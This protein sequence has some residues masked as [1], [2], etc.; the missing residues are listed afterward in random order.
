LIKNWLVSSLLLF[1]SPCYSETPKKITIA[2]GY[3]SGG[4]TDIASK[5]LAKHLGKYIPG[6]PT[7]TIENHPGAQSLNVLKKLDSIFPKDGTYI[8]NFNS[9]L[10][11]ASILEDDYLLDFKNYNWIGSTSKDYN[12]CYVNSKLPIKSFEDLINYKDKIYFSSTGMN[13]NIWYYQRILQN[14]VNNSTIITGFKSIADNQLA[15]IRNEVSASCAQWGPTTIPAYERGDIVPIVSFSKQPLL[16]GPNNITYINNLIID[17][18]TKKMINFFS[19]SASLYRP[20]IMSKDT[21]LDQL[22]IIRK[23]FELTMLDPDF[24]ED[25]KKVNIIIDPTFYKDIDSILDNMSKIDK[26]KLKEY[27]K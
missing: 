4:A 11:N 14:Y 10:I 25:N 20:Y 7:I 19:S 22:N 15:V 6:N 5:I 17:N 8:V 12:F 27:I 24:I 1:S 23:A 18:E 3:V 2:L 16:N 26:K 9:G 21:P 13:I